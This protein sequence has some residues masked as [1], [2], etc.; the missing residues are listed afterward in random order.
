MHIHEILCELHVLIRLGWDVN[1]TSVSYTI[2]SV[3]YLALVRVGRQ[4]IVQG[5]DP[6]ILGLAGVLN[7]EEDSA[8][9]WSP[10]PPPQR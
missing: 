10:P 9:S 3:P 7:L 8:T 4:D 2:Q 6:V 5:P 1:R